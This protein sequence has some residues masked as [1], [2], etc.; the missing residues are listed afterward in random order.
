MR[1]QSEWVSIT[2]GC[3]QSGRRVMVAYKDDR[4]G[5]GYLGYATWDKSTGWEFDDPGRD[6]FEIERWLNDRYT[7]R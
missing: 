2:D 3:P 5:R 1:K 6:H 4:D 7:V